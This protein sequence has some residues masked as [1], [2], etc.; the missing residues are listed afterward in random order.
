MGPASMN[1]GLFYGS[2]LAINA[3]RKLRI[4]LTPHM[5]Q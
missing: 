3:I 5:Q 2:D 1:V 4:G